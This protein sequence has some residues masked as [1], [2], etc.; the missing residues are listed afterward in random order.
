MPINNIVVVSDTHCGCQYGLCPPRARKDGG[1]YYETSF[2]QR[3]VWDKWM[4]FW[5][6][7]VPEVTNG[8]DYVIVHNGDVIDGVHHNA[9]TQISHNLKDQENIAIQV[10]EPLVSDSKCK[11]YYQIRGTEVHSGKSGDSE[12]RI[13]EILKA[14]KDEY[15]NYSRYELW[16]K[17]IGGLGHFTHH[18]GTTNSAA[19]EST[20]V[21]KELVEAYNEAGRY[22]D[23]PPDYIVRSHRHRAYEIKVPSDNGFSH[24]IVT[25]GWQLKTPFV[26]RGTLGRTGTPQIGGIVIRHREDIPIYT[27]AKIWRMDRPKEEV[28]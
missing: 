25:P 5:N 24:A 22:N 8:E 28:I 9:S 13:A 23:K 14:V 20:A 11:A 18:I 6:K 7:F 2:F 3:K 4:E 10:L 1:G 19:Y 17:S 21:H 15:G 12:E 26:Y 27:R 16:L